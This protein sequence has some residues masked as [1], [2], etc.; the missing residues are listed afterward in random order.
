MY[1]NVIYFHAR[2]LRLFPDATVISGD[3][4]ADSQHSHLVTQIIADAAP[5]FEK[6]FIHEFYIDATGMDRFVGGFMWA[7]ELHMRV[8]RESGLPISLTMSVNKIV[9]KIATGEYKPN[10]EE[11]ILAGA[12]RDFLAPLSVEKIP[13]IERYSSQAKSLLQV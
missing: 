9:S 10:A 6:A 7:E 5:A 11:R 3:M 13:G 4:E 1:N 2:Q 12:E 8:I